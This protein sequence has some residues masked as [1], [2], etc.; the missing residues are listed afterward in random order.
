MQVDGGERDECFPNGPSH[1]AE[2]PRG[3]GGK[4]T[5]DASAR[6]APISGLRSRPLTRAADRDAGLNWDAAATDCTRDAPR[7]PS[8]STAMRSTLL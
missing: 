6:E 1:V 8:S 4:E 2:S 7:R 3:D 5:P